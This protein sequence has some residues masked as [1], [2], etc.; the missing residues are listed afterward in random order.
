MVLTTE[1]ANRT[2]LSYLGAR[3]ELQLTDEIAA[4]V[5]HS[6]L[7]LIE[8]YLWEMPGAVEAITRA[9]KVAHANGGLV[10]LTA[11]DAAVVERHRAEIWDALGCGVDLLF[12]NR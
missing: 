12:M 8:G 2:F 1:D 3:Q 6:R 10:A 4:A 9:I 7:L 11:G 5:A